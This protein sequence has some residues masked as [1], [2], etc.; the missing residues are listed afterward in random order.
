MELDERGRRQGMI[1]QN[2][3]IGSG[4]GC[5]NGCHSY[6]T[7]DDDD[8]ICINQ[9]GWMIKS[10]PLVTAGPFIGKIIVARHYLYRAVLSLRNKATLR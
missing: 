8:I 5:T 4:N 6:G 3:Q 7:D 9:Y 1:E 10:F 2:G